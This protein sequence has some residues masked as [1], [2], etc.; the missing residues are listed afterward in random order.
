MP[1]A[2]P[3]ALITDNGQRVLLR[4]D[5]RTHERDLNE[6]RALLGLPAGSR[7]LGISIDGDQFHF[8]FAADQRTVE[9]SARQLSRRLAKQ[10][11]SE[12]ASR[13]KND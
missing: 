12:T 2:S 5:G 10:I 3:S 8:E 9:I 13:A 4:I 6:L 11:T 7:G 1:H